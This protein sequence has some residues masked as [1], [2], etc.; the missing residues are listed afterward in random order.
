MNKQL[1]ISLLLLLS[2]GM[3]AQKANNKYENDW[4]RI[5]KFSEE[6]LPQ[7]ALNEVNAVLKK[8]FAEKN[9]TQVIKALIYKN[10]LKRDI[11]R[12]SDS[13]YSD[14]QTL[15]VQTNNAVEKAL[16]N[17][18]LAEVYSNYYSD[19]SWQINRR[20]NIA[21]F[22]PEDIKEWSG[23]MFVDKIIENL[24]L[25]IQDISTLKK[26]T[27]KEYDDIINLGRDTE[28]YP[29]IYDFLMK[30]AIDISKNINSI[31]YGDSGLENTEV[32]VDELALFAEEYT[33]L[34]IKTGADK[35]QSVFLYY[36]QYLRDLLERNLTSTIIL[37]EMDKIDFI[38]SVSGN[39]SGKLAHDALVR[40][41]K[42]YENN[43]TSTEVISRI[44]N[45]Y[46]WGEMPV[47]INK[48]KYDWL[49]KGIDKYPESYGARLLKRDLALLETP[50]LQVRGK[51]IIYPSNSVKIILGY[52]NIQAISDK[53]DFNLY[54]NERGRYSLVKAYP[55]SLASNT[56]Y[57]SDTLALDL[58]KLPVGRYCFSDISLDELNKKDE[59][60]ESDFV[61]SG[62]KY[63]RFDFVVTGLITFSRNS[64]KSEYEI[65]VADRISGK[66]L[67]DVTVRV[68]PV[69][70][71]KEDEDPMPIFLKTNTM[72]I[73]TYKEKALTEKG[74]YRYQVAQYTV[75]LGADSCLQA[76]SLSENS[77]R[78][79][80]NQ[81]Q[82]D[83]GPIISVLTD[84]SVYRPGQTLFFKAI[85]I[86][87]NSNVI[88]DK[89]FVVKLMNPNN[90][91]VSQKEIIT[92]D[93]GSISGEFIIPQSGLLGRYRVVVD[94]STASVNVEEYKRPTFEITFDK[95]DKTYSFGEKVT[96]KGHA[97]NFSGV[98]LQGT[99]VKYTITRA[100]F[101]FWN[102]R[103]GYKAPFD[104]GT[105]KTNDDGSFEISF[106]PE[107]GDGKSM[108]RTAQRQVYSFEVTATV[109]DVN[110]ET[111]SNTYSVT[112]GNVSMAISIEVESQVE[113]NSDYKLG[114][115]AKNL[116]GVE[117]ETSGSY[118]VSLLDD[119]D[120]IESK[121][122]E[123]AFRSGEQDALK[124]VLKTLPSGKYRIEVK[125][126]DSNGVEVD[127]KT[128]FIL[129]SY[130]DKKPPV[131][132]EGWLVKKNDTFAKDGRPVEIIYGVS[133][134]DINVL[135]QLYNNNG[136]IERRFIKLSDSN[137]SFTIPYKPEYG[138]GV[139]LSFTY[140]KN[141]ELYNKDVTLTKEEEKEDTKLNV[142]LD[143]FR[144]KLRPGQ[145]EIWT[146]SVKD[147]LNNT[148]VAE[149]LASMYDVSLDK[150]YPYSAW[151]LNRPQKY[152]AA[153]YSMNYNYPNTYYANNDMFAHFSL[154]PRISGNGEIP[155]P[156][157]GSVMSETVRRFDQINWFG[158]M[159]QPFDEYILSKEES[160]DNNNMSVS[161]M[162]APA[163]ASVDSKSIDKLVLQENVVQKGVG[164][165][166]A[167]AP[168][169]KSE[170]GFLD[171][172]INVE[173]SHGN[174][175]IRQ[176]FNETAFFFPHLRT[177]EKG[178]T[179]I[180]FTVPES[181][182]TWRFRAMAHDKR[183]RVGVVEQF[184]VTQKELMVT[185]NMPRFIRQ[186][187]KTSISTKIS[188]LS[189]AAIA[190]NVSIEFFDPATEKAIDLSIANASQ[191]F[192]VEKDSSISASWTF[193]VP[194]DIELIGCRIVAQ[195]TTFS[196]GEQ[197]VL[198]VLPNRML[199]T[200][201]MPIDITKSGTSTFTFDKLYNNKSTTLSNYKLTLEYASNP[202]WYAVQALPTLSNPSN[203]NAINWFAAYYV[204]TLG[205]S[206]VRQYPK[207]TTMIEA[208][209]KQGGDKQTLVSKLQKD[210]EL[211][212]V[213]LEE[214]PW[215]MEAKNESEQMQRLSLLFD[216]NNTKQQTDAATKKLSELMNIDGGWS[217]YKGLYSSRAITQYIL[218][219]YAR[220]QL[221]GQVEYPQEIKM[222]QMDALKYI[223]KQILDDYNR[224]SN[225]DMKQG[226]PSL[227]TNQIEYLYVR[228]FYRDIPIN[229]E[230]RQAE[231][232]FTAAATRMWTKL[233]LYERSIL[234]TVLKRNGEKELAD[235]IIK[236]IRE[237]SV[238]NKAQGMYWPNN[239]SNVFMSLSAVST[240]TFLMDALQENGASVDELNAMK[241][242]LLN[243]KRTQVW[244][245]T[246]ATIDAVSTLLS[247]GSDWFTGETTPVAIT[248][249]NKKVEPQNQELGTGYIKQTWDKSEINNNMGKVEV[250]TLASDPAYGALYWQYYEDMDKVTAQ[251]GSLSIEKKLFK[252]NVTASGSSLSS[253][254]DSGSLSVGD[255]VVVRLTI[256]SDKDMT[257]VQ[258]K[259][260]RAPCFEPIQTVS[261]VKWSDGLMYYQ[262]SKDAS[263]NFYFDFL[264][265]GTYVLEYAVYVNR[266][267]EYANGVSTIQCAYAPEYI[268]H[269]QGVKVVVK[270]K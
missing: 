16:L 270:E 210:E 40:L 236:S 209:K 180:S 164:G 154:R 78:W 235:K 99:D 208:W 70:M 105:V 17:S 20:T 74:S 73:A 15:I 65:F 147:T 197:H 267:G 91:I 113:K 42:K 117:I 231:R 196:D 112:V 141:G 202:A 84:R 265:K 234:A 53:Q 246:H 145:A 115:I 217:W 192:S 9:N 48:E 139:N 211:K 59:D 57:L 216:L 195:N 128:D 206:L 41:E 23:N 262:T 140:V 95:I 244:E 51:G 226:T 133:G 11:D 102:W 64:A 47:E 228:S 239:R 18:M 90:E 34:N 58:G 166:L 121:V 19:N 62:Y 50:D 55:M 31:N 170:A 198:A 33:K 165:N 240:H 129:F 124:S 7:S 27:T 199:V 29:T 24:N 182:T 218:Y 130:S 222:M 36:Q 148:A 255:K 137:H 44:V 94:N 14:L 1:L 10:K 247:S 54:K 136:V 168:K 268:S 174:M 63:N 12:D 149:V 171:D 158:Y 86:D 252:E 66:P 123:G 213:L 116:Q 144:D 35:K 253:I 67:K 223:D 126:L 204:N 135:Y 6:S 69:K 132:S 220:L 227:S 167:A 194:K 155:P 243:Q 83:K 22:V 81:P 162:D 176:N 142:K 101:S 169:M 72:G 232:F 181:N 238:N 263:T 259:D 3:M 191:S 189:E 230:T 46:N 179:L 153:I 80:V 26:H 188:N 109:T 257:F 97:K 175:Q 49:K 233:S 245:S 118:T 111:Q 161:V 172:E 248:M 120:V 242:W 93:F 100:Q 146:L 4:S 110:G 28:I 254:D 131:K 193:D 98:S 107:A 77:Y 237:H 108:M 39:F 122:K 184:I 200:E 125:A 75:A 260:M 163:Y 56:T 114:I 37:T 157:T 173:E 32:S 214:T 229:Q 38:S 201:S 79:R 68:K 92:N 224:L 87:N 187:D 96:L 85:A 249:G 241:R 150:I 221:V 71:K 61:Y 152:Q 250:A 215:V 151:Y 5:E 178:E 30:R 13:I 21:D 106:T 119:N 212:A 256:R 251:K 258:L 190:G 45:S 104:D 52:K 261:G 269:T 138:E 186:G 219:G 103:G 43:E 25:S 156:L 205:S 89:G 88:S 203:E 207:V 266:T 185:P 225:K 177:N 76:E 2:I 8:A 134:K 60:V 264:P 127:G 159:S 183:S 160:A 143:V 82:I